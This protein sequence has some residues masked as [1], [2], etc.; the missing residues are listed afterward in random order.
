M[1]SSSNGGKWD[2]GKTHNPMKLSS[3]SKSRLASRP[4]SKPG[5]KKRKVK[6]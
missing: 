4:V 2:H 1:T 5:F 6:K 3:K